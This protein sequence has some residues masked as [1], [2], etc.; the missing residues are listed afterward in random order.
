MMQATS[1]ELIN[2]AQ[3]GEKASIGELFEQ[4]H[5]HVYRYLYYIVGDV[6]LAE[7]LTSEVFLRMIRSLP[8]YRYQGIS[9]QAW[10]FQIAHN[11]AIDHFRKVSNKV[12]VEL[13]ENLHSNEPDLDSTVENNLNSDKLR[14]A[15][16]HLNDAQREVIIL[17]FVAGM[18]INQVAQTLR[19]SEDTVKGLQRRGLASLRKLLDDGDMAYA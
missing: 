1:I 3:S 10:L 4:Y 6:H 18:P 13:E 19:K 9:F 12:Q 15:L 5:T 16:K 14:D 2:R 8:N 17:R 7:D 11:L